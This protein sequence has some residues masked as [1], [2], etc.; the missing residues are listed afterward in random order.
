MIIKSL[1]EMITSIKRTVRTGSLDPASTDLELQS[2][3]SNSAASLDKYCS[4]INSKFGSQKLQ[5]AAS[6]DTFLIIDKNSSYNKS[7][8]AVQRKE[9]KLLTY[10][11]SSPHNNLIDTAVNTN[12][13]WNANSNPG[14]DDNINNNSKM[15]NQANRNET[16]KKRN[17]Q[18]IN[19]KQVLQ[20]ANSLCNEELSNENTTNNASVFTSKQTP[21]ASCFNI[22]TNKSNPN[23][24]TNVIANSNSITI[25]N[26]NTNINATSAPVSVGVKPIIQKSS[27]KQSLNFNS[28]AQIDSN[29]TSNQNTSKSNCIIIKASATTQKGCLVNKSKENSKL[30]EQ[31]NSHQAPIPSSPTNTGKILLSKGVESRKI[32]QIKKIKMK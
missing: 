17:K 13:K 12:S 6:K 25:T 30:K 20:S 32:Q 16:D 29:S 23:N 31:S 11:A 3:R 21:S 28:L 19:I 5:G 8:S 26:P 22:F 9:G 4:N 24:G 1:N 7:D 14:E 2:Q 15:T 18:V 27:Q 10:S